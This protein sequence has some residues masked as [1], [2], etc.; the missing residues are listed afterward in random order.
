MTIRKTENKKKPRNLILKKTTLIV[1]GI[2]QYPVMKSNWINKAKLP[3]LSF[4]HYI[5]T[6]VT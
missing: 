2:I 3:L 5:L 4:A 6:P 1:K